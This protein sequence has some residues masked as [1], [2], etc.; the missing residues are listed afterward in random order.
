[1]SVPF[2]GRSVRGWV[3]G[4]AEEPPPGRILQVRKVFGSARFFDEPMLELFRWVALRYLAPLA[5]VIERSHPPR[6]A[7]EERDRRP[8]TRLAP[9]P[10]GGPAPRP[11]TDPVLAPYGSGLLSPGRVSWLRPLPHEE[12]EVCVAAVVACLAL[13]K[14][15]VVLVPEADPV[16][17]TAAAVLERIGAAAV[18]F[19]G[20]NPRT[21]Y[22]TWLQIQAGQFDVVVATRPGVFV[23]QEDLGLIWISRE[24]H[25]GQREDRAPYYHVAEVAAARARIHG[26][27][28]V[29][30][31]LSPTVETA[32]AVI[33]GSVAVARPV[34]ALER[35]AS[36][37]VE[38]TAPEAEDRSSRLGRLL[39][40]ATGAALIVSRGGYGVAR[41]C[42]SCGE[43][44]A[45][46]TCHGPIV[47]EKGKAVCRVCGAD[48]VCSS[49]GG[50]TF[51]VERGGA[52]RIAEW[53]ARIASVPVD[54]PPVAADVVGAPV[55][56]RVL[57]G[58]AA[59]VKDVGPRS[60]DLVA[61]LD[62]DRALGRAGLHAGEQAL[63][64]WMEA[65]AW[66]APKPRGRVLAQSRRPGHPAIQA[67][68][69]WEPMPFLLGE[70]RKRAEAGFPP[71]HAVF[72]IEGAESLPDDLPSTGADVVVTGRR[73]DRRVCLV[74][75]RPEGL[76]RFR[77][78]ILRL[79]D[80]GI[81]TRVEAE[82]QL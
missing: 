59:A 38:I 7:S 41:V 27:A 6:V 30:S 22:R 11:T 1:V 76:A 44:A 74:T 73:E 29:L 80:A 15:A 49:C 10:P 37:L 64:T 67:L 43:P 77:G 25:P 70:A 45:C 20:G 12:V 16:P 54:S 71:G 75:V 28:C 34:R 81:A 18:S 5:A 2:H 9:Q 4:P 17:A 63:A 57:V 40:D 65:A 62:P 69:R 48:G 14:R 8:A 39:K 78:E 47:V 32:A 82:P 21:R 58:T 36:P 33:A 3:I 56:G 50:P 23:P 13:G 60:L 24:V 52:E 66:A 35:A 79:I 42:R 55:A 72:R 26:T 53:A 46:A 61:I 31:S 68:V 19:L 51:G